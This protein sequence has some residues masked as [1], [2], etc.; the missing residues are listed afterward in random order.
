MSKRQPAIL[1][2]MVALLP[3][4]SHGSMSTMFD[5]YVNATPPR[6]VESATR[7]GTTFGNATVRYNLSR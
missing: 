1:L 3:M 7:V 5:Q 4:L 6:S 2:L